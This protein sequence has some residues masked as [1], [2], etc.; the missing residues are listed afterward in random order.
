[1]DCDSYSDP[2]ETIIYLALSGS[3]HM[4]SG[5]CQGRYG[6]RCNIAKTGHLVFLREKMGSFG[7][8]TMLASFVHYCDKAIHKEHFIL[9]LSF[10][11]PKLFP[12]VIAWSIMAKMCDTG[13]CSL[14]GNQEAR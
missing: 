2:Y 13:S 10:R 11:T 4:A 3:V 14:R 9:P 12:C 6:S 5:P 7:Q 8:R 1:M